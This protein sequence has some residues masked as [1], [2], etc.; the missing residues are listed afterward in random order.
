MSQSGGTQILVEVTPEQQK[1]ITEQADQLG[2]PQS[3]LLIE[4][5]EV[6][7]PQDGEMSLLTLLDEVEASTRSAGKAI[8]EA[9]TFVASSNERIASMEAGAQQADMNVSSHVNS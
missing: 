5:V 8:D 7:A 6:L 4:A 2:I 3:E 9:L 1:T